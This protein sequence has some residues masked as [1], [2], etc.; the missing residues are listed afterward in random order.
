MPFNTLILNFLCY[1]S[2]HAV[3]D[4]AKMFALIFLCVFLFSFILCVFDDFYGP[5]QWILPILKSCH[6]LLR[7]LKR[8]CSRISSEQLS[9]SHA[10]NGRTMKFNPQK[11]SPPPS[12]KWGTNLRRTN[13]LFSSVTSQDYHLQYTHFLESNCANKLDC[14]RSFSIRLLLS[15]KVAKVF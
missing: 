9:L 6:Y 12:K 10:P 14:I 15:K 8:G 13:C 11:I 2:C 3:I 4:G 1:V 7:D 5:F